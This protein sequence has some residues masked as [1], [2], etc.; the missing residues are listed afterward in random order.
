MSKD[1]TYFF[2]DESGD[3]TFFNKRGE[4]IIGQEG[5]SPLLIIGF[6]TTKDP[7]PLRQAIST[8][9]KEIEQDEYLKDIPSISKTNSSFH[10]KDDTPEVREKVYKTVKPLDFKAQFVV[11]RK[12][13]D[14]FTKRHGK[15]EDVFYNEIVARLFKNQL[16]KQDNIIYFSKRSNKSK[17]EHLRNAIKTAIIDFES[18]YNCKVETDS[19]IFIQV[20]TD[21]PCLQI[22][23]Y[24]SWAL[25]RAYIKKDMRYFNF[26]KDKVSLVFDIYDFD[27]YPK[28]FY[29]SKSNNPFDINKTSPL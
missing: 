17:Q 20:P 15:N 24:I 4:C 22:I 12:R 10:A 29:S 26:V 21:E 16:H 25:Q 5:C 13:L 18:Q 1:K 27:R 28:T 8:L 14:V 9:H 23:D 19:E 6:I 7:K 3:P 2:V 11:A